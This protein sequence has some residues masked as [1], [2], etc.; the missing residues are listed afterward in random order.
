MNAD[1]ILISMGRYLHAKHDIELDLTS[2]KLNV[3]IKRYV[4]KMGST[5]NVLKSYWEDYV[6]VLTG[7][8]VEKSSGS[9]TNS[10]VDKKPVKEVVYRGQVV[11]SSNET[12]ILPSNDNSK[13][14]NGLLYR[15]SKQS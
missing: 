10:Q 4:E 1:E 3:Q 14:S 7:G 9:Q 15:G 8:K 6:E 5:D 2:P 12:T 11:S 13:K